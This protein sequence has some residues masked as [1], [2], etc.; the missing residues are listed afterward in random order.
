[1]CRS[2]PLPRVILALIAAACSGS[3]SPTQ[4]TPPTP[5]PTQPPPT[6]TVGV[7]SVHVATV[8]PA[9]DRDGYSVLLDGATVGAVTSQGAL[10]LSA[11]PS[12]HHAVGLGNIAP[13]C[14]QHAGGP[15]E[16]DMAGGDTTVVSFTV[17]CAGVATVRVVTH[18]SGTPPDPDGYVV[19]I[20]PTAGRP[21]GIEDTVE[22]ADLPAGFQPIILEGIATNCALASL[23]RS[24]Y[25]PP[26]QTT[27][28]TFEVNCLA[29]GHGSIVVSVSTNAILVPPQMTFA[30]ELDGAHRLP[31][32]SNG[33]VTYADV[34][35]GEHSVRLVLPVYCGVGLFGGP[36]AALVHIDLRAGER[37]TVP[38][39][40][41]CIG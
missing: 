15:S 34:E 8:G 16:L 28:V 30:V 13:S 41:L 26:G 21:I 40:V 7:I 37:R 9:P 32:P 29:P 38:F 2:R 4:P 1:M 27:V 22:V 33:S 12:G 17:Q 23:Q 19:T 31:V 39:H 36:G 6:P 10:V 11:I 35:A 25:L 5:P 18:T 3:D 24:F 20:G 14:D